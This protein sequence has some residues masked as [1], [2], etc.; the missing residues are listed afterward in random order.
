MRVN[1]FVAEGGKFSPQVCKEKSSMKISAIKVLALGS[2]CALLV[3]AGNT[4]FAQG[5]NHQYRSTDHG[6]FG[7]GHQYWQDS[8]YQ[9]STQ[10]RHASQTERRRLDRLHAAYAR[11]TAH[12]NYS[13]AERDHLHAQA[14]RARLRSQHAGNHYDHNNYDTHK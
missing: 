4:A 13:A 9:H 12:G 1:G 11:A 14:I 10:Y 8:Q 7:Q 2:L 6:Q 3:G 5:Y